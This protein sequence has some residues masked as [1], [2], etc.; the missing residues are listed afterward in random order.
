MKEGDVSRAWDDE[1]MSRRVGRTAGFKR[2]VLVDGVQHEGLWRSNINGAE[3]RAWSL[4]PS[5][6]Q[7]KKAGLSW[8]DEGGYVHVP[9]NHGKIDNRQNRNPGTRRKV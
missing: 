8:R 6:P 5:A 7:K 3:D 9:S 2:A 4:Y 1:A